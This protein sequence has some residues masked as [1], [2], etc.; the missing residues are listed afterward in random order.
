ML[1]LVIMTCL[2]SDPTQCE[3]REL[4]RSEIQGF[5]ACKLATQA[6][7]DL[8]AIAHPDR[9]VKSAYCMAGRPPATN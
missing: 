7:V 3:L 8:W 9:V 5:K 4:E 6:R 2:A 1:S